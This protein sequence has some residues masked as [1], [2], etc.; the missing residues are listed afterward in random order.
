[1]TGA[2]SGLRGYGGVLTHGPAIRPF[3]ASL[4]ARLP[5]S[6][7][8][9]GMIMLLEHVRGAYTLAGIVTGVFAL[10]TALFAPVWGRLMDRHGQPKVIIP[11]ALTSALSL[12][13][14]SLGAVNGAPEPALLALAALCGLSFPPMSPAMRTAW[15]VIF[16]PGPQRLLGYALDASAVELIFVGGPLLLSLL[17]AFTPPYVPLLVTA[18]ALAGG[19]L[20]YSSTSAARTPAP[21]IPV[22]EADAPR[23]AR[24]DA[25]SALTAPGL[26][27]LLAVSL[28][29]AVGFGQLDT[30]IVATAGVVFGSTAQL[31]IL[32]AA[33]AGGS[34]IGGL[35]YG[36][37]SWRGSEQKRMAG[38]LTAFAVT[39]LPV[40]M[41]LL[42]DQPPLWLLLPLM[43]LTGLTIAPTL[44]MFQNTIDHLAPPHRMTEAQAFLQASQTSGGALGM[45][46][47][48][49]SIDHFGAPGGFIGAVVAVAVSA[50][51]SM[52]S[53]RH[54]RRHI[55]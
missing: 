27:A 51:V 20:A 49:I 16:P 8:S 21:P 22:R 50:L 37:R 12:T 30:S 25:R 26:A 32:F 1:M 52:I 46:I 3:T 10:C 23:D 36:A 34:T 13:G 9:L 54:W 31:G 15:R 17:A 14:L 11:T 43:F 24:A 18:A 38:T 45:A 39:L 5:I 40:P 6:M 19:A 28:T 41:L 2:T 4:I 7:A 29:M 42:T 33:I 48:G 53:I 44:I 55:H 47:A 35:V